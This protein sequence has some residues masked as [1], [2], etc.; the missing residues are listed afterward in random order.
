MKDFVE[1]FYVLPKNTTIPA[2]CLELPH[3]VGY[4]IDGKFYFGRRMGTKDKAFVRSVI[5]GFFDLCA[6]LESTSFEGRYRYIFWELHRRNLKDTLFA[7]R[8]PNC[9]FGLRTRYTHAVKWV[10]FM[11]RSSPLTFTCKP[12]PNLD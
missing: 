4:N 11:G 5:R 12:T 6:F 9:E 2:L 3:H 8:P 7:E 1:T 10:F